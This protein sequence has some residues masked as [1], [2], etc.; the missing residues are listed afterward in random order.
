MST[1]VKNRFGPFAL[2]SVASGFLSRCCPIKAGHLISMHVVAFG[3]AKI[4]PKLPPVLRGRSLSWWEDW[5]L[6][7][8]NGPASSPQKF[9]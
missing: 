8:E 5:A 9:E 4:V 7:L 6:V 2:C 1:R 3:A